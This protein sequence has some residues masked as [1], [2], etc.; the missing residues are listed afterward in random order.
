MGWTHYWER[1]NDLPADAFAKA[2]TDC[3]LILAAA[4]VRLAGPH[5]EGEPVFSRDEIAFNGVE[6]Q[7]CEP[8]CIRTSEQPRRPGRPIL[9]Y[10]KT[11]HLPYD[12][13]VKCALIILK[14]HLGDSMKVASDASDPDW[15]DA[16]NLCQVCLGY[17]ANF[18][19]TRE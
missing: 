6:R 18:R 17:G 14:H 2:V 15:D 4:D 7:A 3:R 1:D 19:L 13:C 9:S 5:S 8:F 10:C 12:L 16:R 11:E